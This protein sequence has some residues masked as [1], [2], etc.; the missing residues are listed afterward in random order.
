[1]PNKS[2]SGVKLKENIW[3]CLF[4]PRNSW[5]RSVSFSLST[6]TSAKLQD[7]RTGQVT[8]RM[9]FIHLRVRTTS[10]FRAGKIRGSHFSPFPRLPNAVGISLVARISSLFYVPL[11][12]FAYLFHPSFPIIPFFLL[13]ARPSL[14]SL[15]VRGLRLGKPGSNEKGD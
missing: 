13:F 2:K 14:I 11:L 5:F 10:A 7:S 9:K 15:Q 6:Y 1:M 8:K 3:K 12:P 4:A